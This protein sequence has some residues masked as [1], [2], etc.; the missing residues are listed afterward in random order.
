MQAL[1]EY[2][3]L[4]ENTE[5][6]LHLEGKWSDAHKHIS[7]LQAM[8][9]KADKKT[10]TKIQTSYRDTSLN[11]CKHM[12]NASDFQVGN[13]TEFKGHLLAFLEHKDNRDFKGLT[14]LVSLQW[15]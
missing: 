4:Q 12:A 10:N 15:I 7:V 11:R 8:S 13:H 2:T 6:G 1:K 3:D 14:G 9:I 5:C